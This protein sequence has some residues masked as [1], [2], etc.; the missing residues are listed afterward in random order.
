[1]LFDVLLAAV[2]VLAGS[3]AA[4]SGFGIGSLLTP[5]LALPVGTKLAVAAVAIPH[6][7]GTALRFWLLRRDVDWRVVRSFGITSALGGLTGALLQARASSR[8]LEV[9]FGLLLILAGITELTGWMRRV[10]WGRSAAW[11]AGALSGVLGGLVG[12]QGGIRTAGMLGYD[13][14]KEAF[15]ATATAI[16]LFV[17]AARLPVYLATQ[18]G[19]VTGLE[20]Q[21]L[22][23]TGGVVLGTFL[24]RHI[25]GRLSQ[26]VFRRVVALLL[27]GLGAYMLLG[28][29][30]TVP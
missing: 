24:G 1:L 4:V 7:V 22:I 5:A 11:V 29:N 28:R 14:S 3:V 26:A 15:V 9:V 19:E 23:A 27:L 13:V 25:L 20:S 6:A 2:G 21:V 16:A 12:N 8:A 30:S 18:G 10:R 17:D